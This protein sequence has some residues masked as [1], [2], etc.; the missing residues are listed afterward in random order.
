LIETLR[1]SGLAIID[2]AELEFGP[3][4]NVLTGETGAGKSIVLGALALL[5][6]RRAERLSLREGGSGAAAEAV[7]DTRALPDLERALSERGIEVDDHQLIV[8]R[9]IAAGGRSRARIGGQLVPV[10]ALAE[11]MD[12]RLEISSQHD[13][14]SLRRPDFHGAV[15]DRIGGL[16]AQRAAVAEGCRA[17]RALDQEL[18]ALRAEASERAR[19]RDFLGFQVDEIDAAALDAEDIEALRVERV[20]LA[21]AG[22]LGEE[23]CAALSLVAGDLEGGEGNAADRIGE[24][25]RILEGMQNL[26]PSL[27]GLVAV[28]ASAHADVRESGL[29]L[30]RYVSGIEVDPARLGQI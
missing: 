18:A 4:L 24:A 20:R 22:R 27:A 12:G 23:A 2:E 19:Q 17:L 30:E 25:L 28:L 9:T 29:E 15:V 13:S 3:G 14:Q 1:M 16:E 11:L 8:R 6:G 10:G 7:F 5:S 21:H 26:D